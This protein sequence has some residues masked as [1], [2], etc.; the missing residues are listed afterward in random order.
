M[1]LDD[2]SSAQ[3]RADSIAGDLGL[4]FAAADAAI[5]LDRDPG[6]IEAQ[7]RRLEEL[8]KGTG[9]A[10]GVASAFPQTVEAI[11]R[12]IAGVESRGF[13]IV[14]VSALARD[15]GRR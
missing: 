11:D 15:P 5:D 8:A 9:T 3:S 12:W 10:I 1:M 13:E 14:P 7:L 4:P 2:G 6:A